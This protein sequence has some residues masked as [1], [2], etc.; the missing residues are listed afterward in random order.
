MNGQATTYDGEFDYVVVGSGAGGGTLAA[1]LAEHGHT[2]LVLEAGSDPKNAPVG[3]G[4]GDA[5]APDRDRLPDD[6]DVPTF[7]AF[8]SENDAMKWDYFVRH[9]ADD[10]VQREDDKF[11][12]AE[13][14]VLYPRAGCLGGCTAHNAMITVY[15][16]NRDWDAIAALTG[17]DSWNANAMRRHFERLERCRHRNRLFRWLARF[18]LDPTRHG[19]NG[20]LQTE[21]SLPIWDLLHDR[22]LVVAITTFVVGAFLRLPSRLRRLWWFFA[23]R[24]DPNDWRQIGRAHV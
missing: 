9:Y 4:R 16:A 18:G 7:H 5:V 21:K 22:R 15:P 6:Y 23:A 14:G 3:T 11:V 19:W 20:W 24:L 8:S 17:D 12:A 10:A 1:R 2:V 13:D